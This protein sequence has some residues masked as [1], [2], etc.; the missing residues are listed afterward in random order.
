MSSHLSHHEDF[1]DAGGNLGRNFEIEMSSDLEVREIAS[2]GSIVEVE[3]GTELLLS[4]DLRSVLQAK[5]D[6][7]MHLQLSRD[8]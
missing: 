2:G 7:Q 6:G 8:M 1:N 3:V 4:I 5:P